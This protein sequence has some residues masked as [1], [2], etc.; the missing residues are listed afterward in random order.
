MQMSLKLMKTMSDAYS[1]VALKETC[2]LWLIVADCRMGKLEDRNINSEDEVMR[3]MNFTAFRVYRDPIN[4]I[5]TY[6]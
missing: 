5:L 6:I 4:P 2:N 1:V 3:D